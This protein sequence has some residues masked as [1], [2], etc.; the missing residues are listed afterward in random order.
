MPLDIVFLR[1]Q[2]RSRLKP[3][4]SSGSSTI[5]AGGRFDVD[6]TLI[7]KKPLPRVSKP[8]PGV[9]GQRGLERGWL[10]RLAKGWRRVGGCP[11][12]LQ[13]RNSRGARLE[14]CDSM[15]SANCNLN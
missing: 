8:V 11:C 9:H 6:R 12:T 7:A 1:P 5:T 13:F 4:G 15:E 3:F 14:V 10:K 2:N